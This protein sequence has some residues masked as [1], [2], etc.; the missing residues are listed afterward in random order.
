MAFRVPLFDPLALTRTHE[1]RTAI[2]TNTKTTLAERVAASR[3]ELDAA[4]LAVQAARRGLEVATISV[5][6]LLL[7]R[8]SGDVKVTA[9][10]LATAQA[11]VTLINEDIAREEARLSKATRD[12]IN[13]DTS[14]ADAIAPVL[15]GLP[16]LAGVEVLSVTETPDL[17]DTIPAPVLYLVQQTA[18]KSDP[19]S[20]RVSGEVE[21]IYARP[22]WGQSL[23][24]ADDL[25]EALS[26]AQVWSDGFGMGS[27]E[28]GGHWEDR[29]RIGVRGA[30]PTGLPVISS[31]NG[32][33][34]FAQ[35]LAGRIAD[36]A[37]RGRR[38]VP[39]QAREGGLGSTTALA[40]AV[41]G[42]GDVLS[43]SSTDSKG[44]RTTTVV[45]DLALRSDTVGNSTI[46]NDGREYLHSLVGHCEAGL[47]R[48]TS[49]DLTTHPND[50]GTDPN[51]PLRLAAR[52]VFASALGA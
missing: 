50:D 27:R 52:V 48:I 42:Q 28:V 2:N 31:P 36:H 38:G 47:G 10:D 44:T 1:R 16:S 46:A 9:L 12:L 15:A 41:A 33:S 43:Q 45:A 35:T 34:M 26:R 30:W 4:T 32:A 7:A 17:P 21:V 11:E 18:G 6:N 19:I 25:A 14:L 51:K 37:S 40:N 24:D 49:A 39:T 3:A 13:D 8:R 20:G 23:P 22:A 29:A 5:D